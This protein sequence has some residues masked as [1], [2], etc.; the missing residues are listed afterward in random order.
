MQGMKALNL[1]LPAFPLHTIGI[2]S[3]PQPHVMARAAPGSPAGCCLLF[4][5]KELPSVL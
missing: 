2:R 1:S 5:P 4:R 3:G